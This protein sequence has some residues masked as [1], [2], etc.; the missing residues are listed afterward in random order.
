MERLN[1]KPKPNLQT[2]NCGKVDVSLDKNMIERIN[3]FSRSEN[4]TLFMFLLAAFQYLLSRYSNMDDIVVGTPIAGRN[5]KQ[6]ENLV[7]FFVNNLAIR[8]RINKNDTFQDLLLQVRDRTLKAYENQSLPFDKIVEEL[9]PV[10]DL[11]HQP[12]FQ[13]MFV[14]QNLPSVSGLIGG[15]E[16]IPF[17]VESNTINYQLTLTLQETDSGVEGAIEYNSDLF[18]RETIERFGEHYNILLREILENDDLTLSDIQFLSEDESSKIL[19]KWNIGKVQSVT[20]NVVERFERA[21]EQF[22]ESDAL[23]YKTN[24]PYGPPIELKKDYFFQWDN[25]QNGFF[26]KLFIN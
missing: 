15:L 10:R 8:A 1:D 24:D 11:S 21:V 12:I 9:K 13:V 4:S 23:V 16:F 18:E 14:F 3:S 26:L 20:E 22:S 19:N 6:L 17:E 25:I 5:N 2:T 7:G